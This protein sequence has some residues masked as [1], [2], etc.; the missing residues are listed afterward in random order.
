MKSL[1]DPKHNSCGSTNPGRANVKTAHAQLVQ[2]SYFH[3]IATA[4]TILVPSPPPQQNCI[5]N[6]KLFSSP[7][8]ILSQREARMG[9]ARELWNKDC[10][11]LAVQIAWRSYSYYNGYGGGPRM[12]LA[13]NKVHA[14]IT[15]QVRL[16]KPHH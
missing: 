11:G 13:V 9:W 1:P 5:S 4:I 8:P 2:I 15:L 14:L 12:R 7:D 6:D 3:Q 16:D 10:T